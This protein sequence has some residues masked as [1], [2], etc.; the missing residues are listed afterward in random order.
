MSLSMIWGSVRLPIDQQKKKL[1]RICKVRGFSDENN[2]KIVQIPYQGESMKVNT[3][4]GKRCP[5]CKIIKRKGVIRV[6]CDNPKHKQ[7]QG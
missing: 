3:S 1:K 7:R 2:F 5:K 6:I 4:V